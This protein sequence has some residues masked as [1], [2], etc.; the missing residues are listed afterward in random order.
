MDRQTEEFYTARGE[1]WASF[2]PGEWN[3]ELDPFLDRLPAG[4]HILDLGCGDGRDAV[5]MAQRGFSVD[6]TDG[7]ATM[8]ALAMRNGVHARLLRFDE[9]VGENI[10]DAIYA[11][12]SLHHV[13]ATDLPGILARVHRALKPGGLHFANYKGGSGGGRDEHGRYY[14][15]I[16]QDDLD[17]AYRSAGFSR[18]GIDGAMGRGFGGHATPWLWIMAEKLQF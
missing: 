16:A 14:S 18:F 5:R 17:T 15:Y 1:E 4:A 10:Y 6:A 2:R 3:P 11:N 9:L 8:V 13:P 12:A 7:V